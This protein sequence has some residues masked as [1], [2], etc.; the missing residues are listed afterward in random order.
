M[1]LQYKFGAHQFLWKSHWTDDDL[2]ILDTARGVSQN[3]CPN[4]EPFVREGL[5]F[6]RH[7]IQQA[8]ET[9]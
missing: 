9:R 8:G 1:S 3:L 7:C 5:Q 2:G 4:P 6:L